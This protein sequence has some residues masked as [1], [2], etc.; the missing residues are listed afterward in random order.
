[1]GFAEVGGCVMVKLQVHVVD[2]LR[3]NHD[4]SIESYICGCASN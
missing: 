1:M 3:D 2:R 4:L